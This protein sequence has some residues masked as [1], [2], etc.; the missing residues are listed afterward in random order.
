LSIVY[1]HDG[2][3]GIYG[4]RIFVPFPASAAQTR[5]VEVQS[6]D[7]TEQILLMSL[8]STAGRWNDTLSENPGMI[9]EIGG[10]CA[11]L[12]P[13]AGT[14]VLGTTV[15]QT[16]DQKQSGQLQQS[17]FLST[18]L[19]GPFDHQENVIRPGPWVISTQTNLAMNGPIAIPALT[20][21]LLYPNHSIGYQGNIGTCMKQVV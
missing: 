4:A 2:P 13:I 5:P 3:F 20:Q 8:L 9:M 7:S 19:S 17:F 11:C 16:W 6:Y 15:N 14:A 12:A 1:C 10:S 21:A 18:A